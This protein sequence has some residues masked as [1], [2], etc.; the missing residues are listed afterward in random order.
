M[1]SLLSILFCLGPFCSAAQVFELS[2]KSLT[3]FDKTQLNPSLSER[4]GGLSAM[5]YRAD[6]DKWLVVA[7]REKVAKTSTFFNLRLAAGDIN[8]TFGDFQTL[9]DVQ[10]VESIRYHPG[11]Q[12]FYFVMEEDEESKIAFWKEGRKPEVVFTESRPGMYLTSNRGIEGLAIMP[13]NDLWFAFESGGSATCG[14]DNFTVFRKVTYRQGRRRHYNFNKKKKKDYRYEINR[15]VCMDSTQ[16][17][18]STLGNGISEILA[19]DDQHL[20]VLE[21]CYDGRQTAVR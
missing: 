16:A 15:C 11:Q 18:T 6:T 14:K 2:I 10:N 4:A 1:K 5:E 3:T 13:N 21:R 7:D 19:L 8:Q 9:P 12:G 20:L 17:F